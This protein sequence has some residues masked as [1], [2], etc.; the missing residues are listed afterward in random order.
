MKENLLIEWGNP[1]D[2]S[3]NKLK[4]LAMNPVVKPRYV[5]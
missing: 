3:D 5:L 1:K 2:F 4:K